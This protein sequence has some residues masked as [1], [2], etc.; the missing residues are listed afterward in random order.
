MQAIVTRFHGPTNSRG[1]RVTARTDAGRLT[2]QWDYA[3]GQG[4]HA[5]AAKALAT[6]LGWDGEF[7]EGWLP[8]TRGDRVFVLVLPGDAPTFTVQEAQ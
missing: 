1:S 4:T 6:R 7:H 5:K 8:G 2:V 3:L